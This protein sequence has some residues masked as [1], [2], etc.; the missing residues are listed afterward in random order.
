[1]TDHFSDPN[2]GVE[3]I[4]P[5]DLKGKKNDDNILILDVREPGE[6]GDGH[7]PGSVLIP[8]GDLPERMGELDR[9]KHIYVICR[10]GARSDFGAK[11]LLNDGFNKVTN[12]VPGMMSWTG[13]ITTH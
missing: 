1:M 2:V 5:D 10:S 13:E 9:T 6:Y 3:V 8:L 7:I 11:M 4:T 12:V